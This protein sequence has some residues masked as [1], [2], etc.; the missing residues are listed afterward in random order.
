[1][2]RFNGDLLVFLLILPHS[3]TN[4]DSGCFN[5]F[6]TEA[7]NKN[8]TS[9][10]QIPCLKGMYQVETRHVVQTMETPTWT[11]GSGSNRFG[12][13]GCSFAKNRPPAL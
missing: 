6:Q 7:I 9:F 4:V 13:G 5:F 2:S 11:A 12:E 3:A 10:V 1:M 8:V